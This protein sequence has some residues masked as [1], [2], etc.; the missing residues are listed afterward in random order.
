MSINIT[1][2]I[3][4]EKFVQSRLGKHTHGRKNIKG[5]YR[6]IDTGEI[7]K[8]DNFSCIVVGRTRSAEESYKAALAYF[9][10]TIQRSDES[11]REFVSAEWDEDS[12]EWDKEYQ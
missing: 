7:R 10:Y 6:D 11:E 2:L 4:Y 3:S 12:E 5:V 8:G 1:E 9:N